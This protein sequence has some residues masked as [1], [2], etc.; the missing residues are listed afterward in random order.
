MFTL[1]S[2]TRAFALP[3]TAL[4]LVTV[5]PVTVLADQSDKPAVNVNASVF[6]NAWLMRGQ[7]PFGA[8]VK[9]SQ[10]VYYTGDPLEISVKFGRGSELLANNTA[11][12]FIVIYSV[13]D[14]TTTTVKIPNDIGPNP[15]EFFKL[16][17]VDTKTLAVGQYQL[18]LIVTKPGGDPLKVADWYLGFRGLLDTHAVYITDVPV[19]MIDADH[20]GEVD[21][22]ARHNGMGDDD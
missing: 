8:K 1:R 16:D 18:G 7:S 21:A 9:T 10:H 12:G 22:D 2:M 4:M 19:P 15:R 17:N 5:T 20:D 14:A 11:D 3:L 6:A 13:K